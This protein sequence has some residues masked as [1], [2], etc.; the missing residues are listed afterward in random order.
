[1]HTMREK[2]YYCSHFS[3]DI[4]RGSEGFNSF[5][6]N[7]MEGPSLMIQWLGLHTPR[8]GGPGSIPG[9]GTRSHMPQ[10]RVHMLQQRLN[11]NS[12]IS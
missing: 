2:S 5:P 3:V 9:Q 4:F 1:M 7:M 8:A 12:K 10:L 11:V 6:E